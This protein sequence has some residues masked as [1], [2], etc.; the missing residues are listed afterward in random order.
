MEPI[1]KEMGPEASW[2]QVVSK[3]NEKLIDITAKSR[4][5]A[6]ELT[7]YTIW[8]LSCAEVEVDILTGLLHLKRVDILEDTGE[9]LSP[10]IDVGQ[11]S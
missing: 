2:Q 1:R 8:G 7:P 4:Y 6:E 11:V 3:A 9:S 5:T 10:G